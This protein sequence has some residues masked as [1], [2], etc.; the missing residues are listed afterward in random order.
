MIWF[1]VLTVVSVEVG[2]LT[3]PFGLSVYTIKSA[4]DDRDLAIADI[5]RGAAP[6]ILAMIGVLAILAVFPILSTGLARL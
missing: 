6:F 3:P 1:G 2:L 4:L 5:F